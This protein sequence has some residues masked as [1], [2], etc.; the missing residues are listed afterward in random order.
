MGYYAVSTKSAEAV[1]GSLTRDVPA[2]PGRAPQPPSECLVDCRPS[3]ADSVGERTLFELHASV[4]DESPNYKYVTSSSLSVAAT[5][6][7]G[8]K[9]IQKRKPINSLITA[10]FQPQETFRKTSKPES[11]H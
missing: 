3:T 1:G 9:N 7:K 11:D 10:A 8:V 4:T 5:H 2:M 6:Q